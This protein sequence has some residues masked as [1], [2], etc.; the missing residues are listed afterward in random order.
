MSAG[1]ARTM[2]GR[3]QG[4]IE[5]AARK[6]CGHE[7]TVRGAGRTDAGVHARGQVAHADFEKNWPADTVRD[8]LNAHLGQAGDSVAI[9]SA[10]AVSNEFDA[11]FFSHKP[12]LSLPHHQPAFAPDAGTK[13]GALGHQTARCRRHA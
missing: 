5:A 6:L 13:Q 1:S 12:S 3:L 11:R 4:A 2:D 10:V 8:A 9:I 7:V